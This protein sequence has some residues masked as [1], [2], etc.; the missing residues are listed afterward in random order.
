MVK[1]KEKNTK[2]IIERLIQYPKILEKVEN[3]LDIMEDKCGKYEIG[4]D[5]ESALIPEVSGMGKALLKEWG[6]K[7]A[8]E[9][10][11]MSEEKGL[12]KHSKKK[13]CGTQATETL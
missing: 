8:E 5:A 11:N 6:N 12:K 1:N 2:K 9:K 4:D 13:F 7:K 10:R 3:M